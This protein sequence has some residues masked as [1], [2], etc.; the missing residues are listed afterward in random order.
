MKHVVLGGL[1]AL[2]SYGLAWAQEDLVKYFLGVEQMGICSALLSEAGLREQSYKIR[3]RAEGLSLKGGESS[4]FSFGTW[5]GQG[6]QKAEEMSIDAMADLN[7]GDFLGDEWLKS[8][9]ARSGTE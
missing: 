8:V 7:C 4:S 1:I 3:V 6:Q 9:K 5:F 2:S